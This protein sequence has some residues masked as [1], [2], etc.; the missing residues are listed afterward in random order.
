MS[1]LDRSR[2]SGLLVPSFI[3]RDPPDRGP[4][5]R[6][7][8]L[9]HSILI[10]CLVYTLTVKYYGRAEQLHKFT[11]LNSLI[12]FGSAMTWTEQVTRVALPLGMPD[13][14]SPGLLHVSH[15]QDHGSVHPRHHLL[16]PV[17]RSL[18][19]LH[20]PRRRRIQ[21]TDVPLAHPSLCV[22]HDCR[23]RRQRV[24]GRDHRR[25]AVLLFN[26][27][28]RSQSTKVR[29]A[30][31]FLFS[32][33]PDAVRAR[34]TKVLDRLIAWTIREDFLHASDP[35]LTCFSRNGLDDQVTA[36]TLLSRSRPNAIR[37]ASI[38]ASAMVI[39]VSLGCPSHC[40]H[41]KIDMRVPPAV[42]DDA[43]KL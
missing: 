33:A 41:D 17:V 37:T 1:L 4:S 18:H 15:L 9:A 36:I 40:R 6:F 21:R 19:R 43:N 16:R 8:D 11:C 7:L 14:F 10:S 27:P 25:V 32:C 30:S 34:T 20:L 35:G 31:F 39:S 2:P 26:S 38:T 3:H 24:R 13:A 23:A 29:R 42:Q 12:L 28:P 5:R 22:A